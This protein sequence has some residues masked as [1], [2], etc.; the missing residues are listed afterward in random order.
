MIGL[1]M[2]AIGTPAKIF[3]KKKMSLKAYD[4]MTKTILV[5]TS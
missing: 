1:M 5:T 3:Q 2:G 4:I